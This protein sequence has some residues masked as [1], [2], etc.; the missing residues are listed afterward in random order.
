[1]D[2]GSLERLEPLL[3]AFFDLDMHANRVAGAKFRDIGAFVFVYKLR[4]QRV[5]HFPASLSILQFGSACRSRSGRSRRV[6][7]S[8]ACR[9]QRRICSWF[10]PSSTSGTRSPRKSEGRVYCGQSRIRSAWLNDSITAET[11]FPSTPGM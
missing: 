1:G 11:S 9:R 3:V 10:P 4:Q 8:A 2:Q 6:F 5:V 7:S